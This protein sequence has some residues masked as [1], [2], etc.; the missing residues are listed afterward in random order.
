M[1][2]ARDE[3]SA[4]AGATRIVEESLSALHVGFA[5]GSYPKP[6][7]PHPGIVI[8]LPGSPSKDD[9]ARLEAFLGAGGKAIC[10]GFP[11]TEIAAALGIDYTTPA[12]APPEVAAVACGEGGLPGGPE[13]WL[14]YPDRFSELKGSE[15]AACGWYATAEGAKTDRVALWRSRSVVALGITPDGADRRGLKQLLLAAIA[16][17]DEPLARE[18]VR[19]V[20]GD[21]GTVGPFKSLGTVQAYVSTQGTEAARRLLDT[22]LESYRRLQGA[23]ETA[24]VAELVADAVASLELLREAIYAAETGGASEVRAVFA[25]PPPPGR[26]G[27]LAEGLAGGGFNTVFLY[28]GDAMNPLYPSEAVAGKS[29]QPDL[30]GASCS[31]L[32]RGESAPGVFAWRACFYCAQLTEEERTALRVEGRLAVAGTGETADYLCPTHEQNLLAEEAAIRELVTRYPVEGVVLDF[33]RYPSP[34]YCYCPACREAFRAFDPAMAANWPPLGGQQQ[35]AY[36]RFRAEQIATSLRRLAAAAREA[37]PGVVVAATCFGPG[38]NAKRSVGQDPELWVGEGGIDML[39]PLLYTEIGS[40]LA[41]RLRTLSLDLRGRALLVPARSPWPTRGAPG[42]PLDA[43]AE[44][45]SMRAVQVDGLAYYAY[46]LGRSGD[47]AH[48]LGLGAFRQPAEPAYRWPLRVSFDPEPFPAI[49][50]HAYAAD[51]PA[52]FRLEWPPGTSGNLA[53]VARSLEQEARRDVGSLAVEDGAAEATADLPPGLWR[54]FLEGR[55]VAADGAES[56][57]VRGGP[58]FRV[59]TPEETK[60]ALNAV[61][62]ASRLDVALYQGGRGVEAISDTFRGELKGEKEIRALANLDA[63]DLDEVDLLVIQDPSDPRAFTEQVRDT[64][65]QWVLQGGRLLLLHNAVGHRGM[66]LL[67]PTVAYVEENDRSRCAAVR[68]SD[69]NHPAAAF[70]NPAPTLPT[71]NEDH[72]LVRTNTAGIGLLV[73]DPQDAPE[74]YTA[75][76]AQYGAGRVVLCGIGFGFEGLEEKNRLSRDESELL[77]GLVRWLIEGVVQP[78]GAAPPP[79]I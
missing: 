30:F 18:A 16:A 44:L 61:K 76:A 4:Y 1:I 40:E 26:A 49:A 51:Q 64:L 33:L 20:V 74:T 72:A 19:A 39:V 2:G 77:M 13:G 29:G 6:E 70:L 10:L 37:R 47:L 52:R 55:I 50:P 65:D 17:L 31:A 27:A 68:V 78:A 41:T 3:R 11:G 56:P 22:A 5:P 69:R 28:A 73:D 66:P 21:F 38:K 14:Q 71:E 24:P 12:E 63:R 15:G 45:R 32:A 9:V 8:L 60:T 43:L 58:V 75:V 7:A 57:I 36:E 53:M 25:S 48:A 46:Q 42:E 35:L 23:V 54:V 62:Q 59:L 79:P 34:N 67:F